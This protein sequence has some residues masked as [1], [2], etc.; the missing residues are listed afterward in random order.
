MIDPFAHQSEGRERFLFSTSGSGACCALDDIHNEQESVA[1]HYIWMLCC[2]IN[3]LKSR[4][5]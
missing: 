5:A 4:V 1:Y 2:S 3:N